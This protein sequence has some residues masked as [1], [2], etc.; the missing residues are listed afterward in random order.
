MSTFK[1]IFIIIVLIIILVIIYILKSAFS[2]TPP[3]SVIEKPDDRVVACTMDAFQCPDG[4]Y[5][6]RS[7]PNCEFVCPI[8]SISTTTQLLE[9]RLILRLDETKLIAST[10]I[11]ALAITEDSRCPSD[12]LCIQAGK[13]V[14]SFF[15]SGADGTKIIELESGTTATHGILSITLADVIPYPKS[16]S[17]ISNEEYQFVLSVK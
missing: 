7:A 5:V 9:Q 17:K 16:T 8:S 4:S 6:G 1:H 2:V 13:V 12:A 11:K 15:V 3:T 10:T 14:A